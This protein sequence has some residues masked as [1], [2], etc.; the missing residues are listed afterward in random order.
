MYE[1]QKYVAKNERYSMWTF[2][3]NL[4]VNTRVQCELLM[5]IHMY[6]FKFIH[7]DKVHQRCQYLPYFSFNSRFFCFFFC[8]G[9][10]EHVLTEETITD[11]F[12]SSNQKKSVQ[13]IEH[14]CHTA[15]TR[16][17][18]AST[19]AS[20]LKLKMNWNSWSSLK[21]RAGERERS[22]V[23]EKSIYLSICV[24]V[25]SP[26]S[27]RSEYALHMRRWIVQNLIQRSIYWL[28]IVLGCLCVNRVP[29]E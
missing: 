20:H 14:L 12:S 21:T 5:L 7:A 23:R 2:D 25:I 28:S 4:L 1:K 6:V 19:R 18:L 17:W 22:R 15:A 3:L 24:I 27:Y 26:Y 29:I 10:C 9:M 13:H 16:I 11:D 8:L